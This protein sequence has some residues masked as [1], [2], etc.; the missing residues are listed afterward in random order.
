VV[1]APV[2]PTREL[3]TVS[4]EGSDQCP[5]LR[6]EP[7]DKALARAASSLAMSRRRA[8]PDPVAAERKRLKRLFT[9]DS[10]CSLKLDT[11]TLHALELNEGLEEPVS[12]VVA[13][14][15]MTYVHFKMVP[16]DDL[17]GDATPLRLTFE[18]AYRMAR[19]A[20]AAFGAAPRAEA[21][22]AGGGAA[23][24]APAAADEAAG[25]AAASAGRVYFVLADKLPKEHALQMVGPTAKIPNVPLRVCTNV[26]DARFLQHVEAVPD[27]AHFAM[28]VRVALQPYLL[29]SDGQCQVELAKVGGFG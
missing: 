17:G 27:N 22:G 12:F 18:A 7:E 15:G 8:D 6:A 14:V 19:A 25:A 29:D 10:T 2:C 16:V 5:S 9:A 13:S 4:P 28:A 1:R 21:A 20:D 23:D 3:V 11:E 26:D 24:E